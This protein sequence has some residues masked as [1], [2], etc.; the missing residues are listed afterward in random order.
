MSEKLKEI[1]FLT[2]KELKRNDVVLPG[3]YS[4]EF[5][6]HAGVLEYDLDKE[7][8]VLK[9]VHQD[10]D[11]I[12]FVVQKTNDNISTLKVST[13]NAKKAIEEKNTQ[14][15]D[16]ITSDLTKMQE[17]IA[18]LEKE[19]FSDSLTKAYNRKWF[20]DYL[21]NETFPE[22]GYLAFIDL[23]KFKT[24]NDVH[25][26]ITGDQVLRFLVK[27]LQA[28]FNTEAE[29][30]VRYAG[31]EFM[32]IFSKDIL[33]QKRNIKKELTQAQEKLAKL[34]LKSG[35]VADLSFGFSFGLVEFEIGNE[36]AGT[37]EKADELMYKNK[38]R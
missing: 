15:L 1:T 4:K 36:L 13:V 20:S 30:V 27:F 2:L 23:D 14:S 34:K 37:L 10:V 16:D 28:E 3:E 9:D 7:E 18:F 8:V 19:L 12:N 17:Q 33:D 21:E 38:K 5:A 22:D 11:K 25:G 32:V 6:K 26:H 29:K 35:K 24:I 31:D